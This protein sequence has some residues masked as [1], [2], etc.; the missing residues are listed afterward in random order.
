MPLS[1]MAQASSRF[2]TVFRGPSTDHEIRLDLLQ[3]R[4]ENEQWSRR[5]EIDYLER[6]KAKA[7]LQ[8]EKIIQE[9]MDRSQRIREEAHT[10]IRSQQA[11]LNKQQVELEQQLAE[12]NELRGKAQRQLEKARAVFEAAQQ[13]GFV[14]GM[15]EAEASIAAT[16]NEHGKQLATV[17]GAVQTQCGSI[18][19]AWR[20]SLNALLCQAVASGTGW[21]LNSEKKAVL[22]ALLGEAV[23]QLENRQ[24]LT[25]RANPEDAELINNLLAANKERFDLRCW[26]FIAD[27]ALESGGLVLESVS[28]KVDVSRALHREVVEAALARLTLPAGEADEAAMQAVAKAFVSPYP[29]EEQQA[30]LAAAHATDSLP[31]HAEP[32]GATLPKMSATPTDSPPVA[33]AAGTHTAATKAD[34]F[35]PTPLAPVPHAVLAPEAEPTTDAGAQT[36]EKPL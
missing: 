26:E 12:A 28:G 21:V 5:T 31:A 29:Q 19:E 13:E 16:A 1:N 34:A 20:K 7:A 24:R 2:G 35:S 4:Q 32:E 6:V 27:A 36:P 33:E 14:H 25:V 15:Q 22:E 9:G 3:S 23:Q 8:A 10:W 11:A 18:F 17:L 30:Q